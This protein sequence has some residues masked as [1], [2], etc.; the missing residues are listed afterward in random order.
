MRPCASVVSAGHG[1][2]GESTNP[3]KS[4]GDTFIAGT[5]HD[6][7]KCMSFNPRWEDVASTDKGC[8]VAE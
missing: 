4:L 2:T 7:A 8:K 5:D 1:W 6:K 3:C